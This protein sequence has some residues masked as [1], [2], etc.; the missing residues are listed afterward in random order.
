[1]QKRQK[2]SSLQIYRG[3]AALMVVFYHLTAFGHERLNLSFLGDAF[4]FGHVGVDFFF[5][6]SGFIIFY[7]NSMDVGK[8]AQIRPYLK[9][10][11]VRVYPIY[12]IVTS[13]KVLLLLVFPA[14]AKAYEM[15][16]AVILKSYLL[17]PQANLPIIGAAWTLSY[18]IM[19]YLLFGIAILAGR[20]WSLGIF[21]VWTAL[22]VA[23]AL[24]KAAGLALFPE[25]VFTDFL[26]NERNLEFIL[27]CL[28]AYWVLNRQNRYPAA[29]AIVGI[30]LFAL[31]A[32][33]VIQGGTVTSYTLFFGVASFLIVTGS[34]A[35]E[36]R[37]TLP[38]PKALVFLGDASYS[39]YLTHALFI[40]AFTLGFDR[41]GIFDWLGGG[42]SI[43]LMAVAVVSAGCLVY[44]FVE[45][46]LLGI[47]N[48]RLF[49]PREPSVAKPV[50]SA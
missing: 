38:L 44:V 45:K 32:I 24:S 39:V 16:S 47:L 41:L 23:F 33:Y 27:G 40:N 8:P 49:A 28:S 46:P 14:F 34:A 9:R 25:G 35:V 1:M 43:V 2:I 30:L 26:F 7:V 29:T 4:K 20:R 12:W 17:I 50:P 21:G 48:R 36:M 3:L 37:G 6:L 13:A 22:I 5:V 42:F 31:S 18:E 19:F 11:F 15:N 10:R